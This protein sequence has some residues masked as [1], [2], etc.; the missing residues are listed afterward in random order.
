MELSGQDG[1]GRRESRLRE[2]PLDNRFVGTPGPEMQGVRLAAVGVVLV[3]AVGCEVPTV[4]S[5]VDDIPQ[6]AGTAG[7]RTHRPCSAAPCSHAR[8]GRAARPEPDLVSTS[9]IKR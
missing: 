6:V 8:G 1:S 4:P 3:G 7:L 2:L 9:F 5:A